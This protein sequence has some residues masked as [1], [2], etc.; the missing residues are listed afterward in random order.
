MI[1]DE[2]LR[3]SPPRLATMKPV[4]HMRW[5]AAMPMPQRRLGASSRPGGNA[6]VGGSAMVFPRAA[7]HDARQASCRGVAPISKMEEKTGVLSLL[8]VFWVAAFSTFLRPFFVELLFASFIATVS[9][10]LKL[11]RLP[12]RGS[13]H[14]NLPP[15]APCASQCMLRLHFLSFFLDP[16]L[17]PS[18]SCR[19][20]EV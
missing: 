13:S 15:L 12:R 4:S 7:A 3:I 16:E 1:F 9:S 2:W 18:P 17:M 5:D 20:A 14:I 19:C 11:K 6:G 10:Y 8:F